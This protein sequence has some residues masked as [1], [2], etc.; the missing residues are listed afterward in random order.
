LRHGYRICFK[1]GRDTKREKQGVCVSPNALEDAGRGKGDW[2]I[3]RGGK[4]G[5]LSNYRGKKVG[6]KREKPKGKHIAGR[7]INFLTSK[8]RRKKSVGKGDRGAQERR[9]EKRKEG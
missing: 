9:R 6:K 4:R 8:L 5:G 2:S 1:I 7:K 3:R